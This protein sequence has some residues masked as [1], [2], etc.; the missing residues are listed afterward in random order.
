MSALHDHY[1]KLTSPDYVHHQYAHDIH[2][3]LPTL[4]RLAK[5][6]DHIT[7]FGVRTGNSSTAFLVGL[8]EREGLSSLIGYDID[9][10]GTPFPANELPAKLSWYVHQQDTVAQGFR[11]DATELLFVDSCHDYPHVI[12]ELRQHHAQ[13]SRYIVMHDVSPQWAGGFGPLKAM[14]EFLETDG[15]GVWHLKEYHL[16]NNG[17]AVLA[18]L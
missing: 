3:H 1:A 7:E 18:R 6:C 14:I 2:E 4:R 12:Q 16:N 8:S 17:L 10:K 13:I 9:P 15:R 11:I 5:E